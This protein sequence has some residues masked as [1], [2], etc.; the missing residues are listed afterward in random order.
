MAGWF[1]GCAITTHATLAAIAASQTGSL[2]RSLQLLPIWVSFII[3]PSGKAFLEHCNCMK[4]IKGYVLYTCS[5][6]QD[7]LLI[8]PYLFPILGSLGFG[9]L[10]G[11]RSHLQH[12]CLMAGFHYVIGFTTFAIL[13]EEFQIIY[14]ANEY[15]R[16]WDKAIW[17]V[18]RISKKKKS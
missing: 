16:N 1:S 3:L 14:K 7:P 15:R 5:S 6:Q 2:L 12:P 17:K 11:Y 4:Q 10:L 18:K 8:Q 13:L 9:Q